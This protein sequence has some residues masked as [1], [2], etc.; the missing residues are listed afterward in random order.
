MLAR[1][2]R[3]R[4]KLMLENPMYRESLV[5]LLLSV[6]ACSALADTT[7]DSVAI[8]ALATRQADAWN[9]H[10]AKAY[11]ALFTADCD[12]VNV[13]GAWWN[14]RTEVERKL[15]PAYGTVFKDSTLTFTDVQVRFLTPQLAVAHMR[16]TM[17]GATPPP[18]FPPIKQGIQTLLVQKQAHEWSIEVFQNTN[19]IPMSNVGAAPL[20]TDGSAG[21]R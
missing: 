7:E 13:V 19:S 21:L 18:G 8:R 11:A 14:G 4:S 9:Q 17:S 2:G 5:A 12:V 10:D 6:V 1:T 15:T 3:M 16:W 20:G